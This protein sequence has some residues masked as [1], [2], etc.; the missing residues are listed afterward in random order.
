LTYEHGKR[1]DEIDITTGSLDRAEDFPPTKDVY[2]DERLPW[3]DLI[4]D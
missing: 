4:H 2:P 3:V 1:A